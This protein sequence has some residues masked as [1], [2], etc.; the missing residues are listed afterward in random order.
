MPGHP[1]ATRAAGRHQPAPCGAARRPGRGSSQ[2]SARHGHGVVR[3]NLRSR[4]ASVE[5]SRLEAWGA[6]AGGLP[7][8]LLVLDGMNCRRWRG[9]VPP[10]STPGR[11][12]RTR[13]QVAHDIRSKSIA[14]CRRRHRRHRRRPG[15]KSSP[16]KGGAASEANRRRWRVPCTVGGFR[17]QHKRRMPANPAER[18]RGRH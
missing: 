18:R 6:A 16:G 5:A 17:N 3:S 13:L 9:T 11:K 7:M 15:L 1:R 10:E 8:I 12:E 14:R 2:R 4:C